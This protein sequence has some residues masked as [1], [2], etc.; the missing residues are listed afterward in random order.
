MIKM[1][2]HQHLK[3]LQQLKVYTNPFDENFL[4]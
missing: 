1:P 3:V 4:Q 2:E